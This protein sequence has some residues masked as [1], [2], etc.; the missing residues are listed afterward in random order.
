MVKAGKDLN[1][2]GV[3]DEDEEDPNPAQ[4]IWT[5]SLTGISGPEILPEKPTQFYREE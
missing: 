3:I 2:N 5:I 4:R 1:K